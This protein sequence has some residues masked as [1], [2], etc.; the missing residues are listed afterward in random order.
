MY[1]HGDMPMYKEGGRDKGRDRERCET[2][3]GQPG[4]VF[5]FNV[6]LHSFFMEAVD[7]TQHTH[8]RRDSALY[9]RCCCA[10]VLKGRSTAWLVLTRVCSV[11]RAST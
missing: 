3:N 10:R 1:V 4:E 9:L 7:N 6:V 2:M 11:G 8:E 5:F